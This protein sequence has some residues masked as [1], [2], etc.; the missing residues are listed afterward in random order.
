V[1]SGD[2]FKYKMAIKFDLKENTIS[3]QE[4]MDIEGAL[5][6]FEI[7]TLIRTRETAVGRIEHIG[8]RL[9]RYRSYFSLNDEEVTELADIVAND[10]IM[11]PVVSFDLQRAISQE[12]G[13]NKSKPIFYVVFTY[14]HITIERVDVEGNSHGINSEVLEKIAGGSRGVTASAIC[15]WIGD[16]L[17]EMVSENEAKALKMEDVKGNIIFLTTHSFEEK[18]GAIIR[19]D[20]GLKEKTTDDPIFGVGADDPMTGVPVKDL[21]NYALGARELPLFCH[22]AYAV[23]DAVLLSTVHKA[24]SYYPHAFLCLYLKDGFS[25]SV[26][27]WDTTGNAFIKRIRFDECGVPANNIDQIYNFMEYHTTRSNFLGSMLSDEAVADLVRMT[28][29]HIRQDTVKSDRCWVRGSLT[30]EQVIATAY[31]GA[32]IDELNTWM[33]G[34]ADEEEFKMFEDICRMVL[35]R[36]AKILSAVVA[37]CAERSGRC[38]EAYGTLKCIVTGSTIHH[39]PEFVETVTRVTNSTIKHGSVEIVVD[40]GSHVKQGCAIIGR[41]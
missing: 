28:F 18:T 1:D 37:G 22:K 19:L 17:K 30:I 15:N 23:T 7:K 10:T 9:E 26:T 4:F 27:E 35:I 11:S 36:A 20:G 40:D 24:H 13:I 32:G 6:A 31:G 25:A 5:S 8:L 34:T 3:G 12:A 41:E 14:H 2:R 39:C 38:Y 29:C 33:G 16:R 21:I